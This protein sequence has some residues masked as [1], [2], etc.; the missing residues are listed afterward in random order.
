LIDAVIY[1]LGLYV[2]VDTLQTDIGAA[3]K[4]FLALGS[5]ST[6][7]VSLA[8]QGFVAQVL[9]GLFLASSNRVAEGDSV[10]IGGNIRGER[11]R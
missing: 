11:T 5:V 2:I 1:G 7:V 6:L 3:T 10:E 4:S 8:M 9:H